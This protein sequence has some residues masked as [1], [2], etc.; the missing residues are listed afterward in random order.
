MPNNPRLPSKFVDLNIFFGQSKNTKMIF[1]KILFMRAK[2]GI[3]KL[4]TLPYKHTTCI[5]FWNDI[6]LKRHGNGRLQVVSTW[7]ARGVF[8]GKLQNCCRKQIWIPIFP[9]PYISILG[10]DT[11]WYRL[12]FLNILF[13]LNM[14][15]LGRRQTHVQTTFIQLP[16]WV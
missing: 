12:F 6:T 10:K 9:F 13:N 8:V 14:K 5:S 2:R 16:V 11:G 1:T 3:K 15:K 4:R 7:N